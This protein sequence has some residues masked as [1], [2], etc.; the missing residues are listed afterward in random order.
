MEDDRPPS[1][2]SRDRLLALQE[3]REISAISESDYRRE[4]SSTEAAAAAD[5]PPTSQAA[6][7]RRLAFLRRFLRREQ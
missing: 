1:E 2:S 6:A 5:V 4:S 3:L 7:R